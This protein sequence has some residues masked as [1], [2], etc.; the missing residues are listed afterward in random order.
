MAD[1][2]FTDEFRRYILQALDELKNKKR[3]TALWTAV[4]K[5]AEALRDSAIRIQRS[6]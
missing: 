5:R 1:N 6:R 2:R 3:G 4:I